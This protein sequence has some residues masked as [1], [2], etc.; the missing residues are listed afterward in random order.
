MAP[1][2]FYIGICL[3]KRPAASLLHPPPYDKSTSKRFTLRVSFISV[4]VPKI[5]N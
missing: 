4:N 2:L 1:K 3:R 5:L